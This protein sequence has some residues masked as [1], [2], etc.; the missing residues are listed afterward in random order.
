MKN[1]YLLMNSIITCLKGFFEFSRIF[2][3]R[4]KDKI[5]LS[6][7]DLSVVLLNIIGYVRQVA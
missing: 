2:S 1:F 7:V 5:D 4:L 3:K 6:L